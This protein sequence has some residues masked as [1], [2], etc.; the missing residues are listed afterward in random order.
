MFLFKRLLTVPKLSFIV[1]LSVSWICYSRPLVVLPLNDPNCAWMEQL[2]ERDFGQL[3]K[4]TR[5]DL[6][7][8]ANFLRNNGSIIHLKVVG[9]QVYGPEGA[10]ANMLRFLCQYYMLPDLEL[11]YFQMDGINQAPPGKI[12][13]FT[14]AR[15][16]GIRNTILFVD[17]YFQNP[18]WIQWDE[19]LDR[20]DA[21]LAITPWSSRY[22]KMLWRG[23]LT[24]LDHGGKYTIDNWSL[25]PRGKACWLSA[26]YP[27][28]IDAAVYGDSFS[29]QEPSG[30]FISGHGDAL[31]KVI[32]ITNWIPIE[33]QL[34]Y[35]YQLMID[36]LSAP[37]SRDWQYYSNSLIFRVEGT[38][39][40][41]WWYSLL[42]PWEHYIPVA[43][44]LSDLI[45]KIQ[46][47]RDHDERAREIACNARNLIATHIMPEHIALYCYKVLLRYASL[48]NE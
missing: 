23:A 47:F 5:E 30:W 13:V 1:L 31:R 8:A 9:N 40:E 18:P 32:P 28:L 25:H 21:Q 19:A 17:W 37:F 41:T 10:G 35:K 11:F 48:F 46:W 14:G 27:D 3:E 44:D 36:G 20:I 26:R 42:Q 4:I 43:T 34:N 24:D 38:L 39:Y 12:P 29:F 7:H 6:I 45:E 33:P 16:K 2:I 22:S 15:T